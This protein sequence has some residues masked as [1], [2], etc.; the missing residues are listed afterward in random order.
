MRAALR[1]INERG[2]RRGKRIERVVAAADEGGCRFQVVL[3]LQGFAH[4]HQWP[5]AV[6][7]AL[8]AMKHVE[9]SFS[10]HAERPCCPLD[11]LRFL[12]FVDFC[13]RQGAA[14][15][16]CV[17]REF[18]LNERPGLPHRRLQRGPRAHRPKCEPL[19]A[20]R[21]AI[22]AKIFCRSQ[23][24]A[25][26]RSAGRPLQE[27]RLLADAHHGRLARLDFAR[28]RMPRF[29]RT[30]CAESRCASDNLRPRGASA[31]KAP[32]TRAGE[33][34]QNSYSAYSHTA[35]ADAISVSVSAR[36]RA[37]P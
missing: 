4:R 1:T 19:A 18:R 14:R 22:G 5:P 10:S 34:E 21:C 13:A 12:R 30:A 3:Q 2:F 9:R 16:R 35:A 23:S 28:P 27:K 31:Q 26:C 29:R 6:E 15:R 7:R 36:R 33:R 11:V 25:G 17:D 37:R 24:G 20:H 32:G 8:G